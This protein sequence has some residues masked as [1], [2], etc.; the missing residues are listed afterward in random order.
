MTHPH[1]A[2]EY[3]YLMSDDFVR[4]FAGVKLASFTE[5]D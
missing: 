4:K 2:M 3:D 1:N 5:Q